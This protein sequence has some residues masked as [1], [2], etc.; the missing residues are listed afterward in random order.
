MRVLAHHWQWSKRVQLL[1]LMEAEADFPPYFYTLAEIGR[2]GRGDIPKR[3]Y[4]MQALRDRGYQ[5]SATH[6]T[7]G[8]IKTNADI[9]T[10]ITAG[11]KNDQNPPPK[12]KS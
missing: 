3:D 7:P 2:R 10:C 4:L 11:Q 9:H 5:A 1:T 12:E 8:A 6:I